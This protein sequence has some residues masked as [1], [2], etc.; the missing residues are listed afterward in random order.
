MSKGGREGTKKKA[1]PGDPS[2]HEE[3]LPGG[4]ELEL[5]AAR[6]YKHRLAQMHEQR[7]GRQKM[8]QQ[9]VQHERNNLFCFVLAPTTHSKSNQMPEFGHAV[10]TPMRSTQ[11]KKLKMFQLSAAAPLLS[12]TC[13]HALRNLLAQFF[14]TCCAFCDFMPPLTLAV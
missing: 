3:G 14:A 1:P 2:S 8:S 7:D 4:A 11:V 10:C 5:N 9:L 6:D 13:W 12:T